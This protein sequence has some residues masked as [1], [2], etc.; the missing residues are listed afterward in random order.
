VQEHNGY[1]WYEVAQIQRAR[2]IGRLRQLD[3]PLERIRALLDLP[4]HEAAAALL[5]IW[6][7]MEEMHTARGRLVRYLLEILNERPGDMYDIE[8]T[9]QPEQQLLSVL[10][11][12]TVADLPAFIDA[13]FRRL[14]EHVEASEAAVDGPGLVIYHGVVDETSDGPVEVALPCHGTISPRDDLTVRI[15][16]ARREAYTRITKAQ[17]QFPDI[18]R[19]YD[20]VEAWLSSRGLAPALSPRESYFADWAEIGDDDPA[21]DIVFPYEVEPA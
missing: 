19:A 6:R 16:P 12:V 9:E 1:R 3:L 20:S 2:L 14:A 21:C 15:E 7:E 11:H 10:R 17:V 8:T 4:L 5:E 18:L 13:S